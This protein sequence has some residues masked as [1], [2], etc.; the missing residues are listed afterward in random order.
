MRGRYTPLVGSNSGASKT[1]ED[2]AR[3]HGLALILQFG[4]TAP[5]AVNGG[6]VTFKVPSNSSL[7]VPYDFDGVLSGGVIMGKMVFTAIGS[8]IGS[9]GFNTVV[10][11]SGS[12]EI[13]VSLR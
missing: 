7:A 5:V 2:L 12:T 11:Q 9:G 6:S 13:T 3:R 10:T 8:T 4:S 1:L